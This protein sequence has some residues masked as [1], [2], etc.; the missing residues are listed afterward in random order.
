[1]FGNEATSIRLLAQAEAGDQLT[2]AVDVL[3]L[4][5]VEE[6][7]T[8]A[9][10]HQQTTTGVMVLDVSLE[11]AGQ[12]VDAGGKQS[13]LH[14]RRTGI[15][16]GTLVVA[17]D[18]RFLF[19]GDCHCLTRLGF[20]LAK[21]AIISNARRVAQDISSISRR[22]QARGDQLPLLAVGRDP[23]E[24]FPFIRPDHASRLATTALHRLSVGQTAG[25]SRVELQH[26]QMHQQRVHGR[27]AALP[28]LS[29]D[30]L[31][32]GPFGLEVALPLAD[33]EAVP[34]EAREGRLA[35]VDALL[36]HL[37]VLQL[38]A[39]QARSLTHG[40]PAQGCDGEPGRMVRAYEGEHFLGVATFGEA[41]ELV[42]T[43]LVATGN[44]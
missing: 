10:H 3:A 20:S 25:L 19:S 31:K 36:V 38:D 17:N 16:L 30:G 18:L 32:I 8:L 39:A 2:I 15:T 24:M 34:A 14:F 37:P 28:L 33:F 13:D 44:R 6:L 22:N 23:E 12:I 35:S 40:Q 11:V 41:G 42:P 5:V 7:A 9:H 1:M 29:R 27:Q 21:R 4:Q 43:R 26:G